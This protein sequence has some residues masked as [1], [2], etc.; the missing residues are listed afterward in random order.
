MAKPSKEY[1]YGLNPA[2]EAVR[3]TKRIVY[4]A[5]LNQASK[6]NARMRKLAA[7]LASKDIPVHWVERGRVIDLAQTKDHQGVALQVSR[8]PY[9]PFAPMLCQE[10]LLLL[11]NVEDPHNVGAL[12][13]SAEVFGFRHILLSVKGTPDVYPSV[14]KVSAGATEFL[15]ITKDASAAHYTREALDAGYTV[16]ALD[17]K[18]DTLLDHA[19]AAGIR[20]LLLVI[21]GEDQAVGQFVLNHAHYVV[22]IPQS[23]RVNSLNASVAGAI[24]MYALRVRPPE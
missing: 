2:F 15:D 12:L 22:T 18:G 23:G 17:A 16:V 9:R 20:R 8:Y 13:R 3:S 21:G 1:L 5:F 4:Q 19:A 7:L 24:A 10:R 6:N 11:D 14:V